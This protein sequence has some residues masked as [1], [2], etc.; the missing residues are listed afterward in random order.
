M[1]G[2]SRTSRT[3]VVLR[4]GSSCAVLECR[5][6]LSRYNYALSAISEHWPVGRSIQISIPR[7]IAVE[8]G[9]IRTAFLHPRIGAGDRLND[10]SARLA[11][12]LIALE[13]ALD[14]FSVA[15]INAAS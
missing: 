12:R 13:C 9:G 1:R 8:P 14:I 15:L 5:A 3:P 2:C 7:I 4:H 11:M 6:T 10:R